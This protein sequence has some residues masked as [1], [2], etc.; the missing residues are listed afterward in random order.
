[1]P[2]SSNN[3]K[4]CSRCKSRLT[5]DDDFCPQCGKL[6]TKNANCTNHT[7]LMAE[8]VCIICGKPRCRDCGTWV[9]KRYL[10][11]AHAEYEIYEGM[12]RVFGVSDEAAAQYV[13]KCLEQEGLHPLV[14]ERKASAISVGGPDYTLFEA[15][16]EHD[17]HIIN[18]VKVMVPCREVVSA[19]RVLKKL[20]AK[21]RVRK[22][23][24]AGRSRR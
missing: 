4:V 14:Y 5:K 22:N 23:S 3:S 9:S 11:S 8:G 21:P 15:S 7:A 12:A 19:E 16:G 24:K 20:D 18:E 10:C 1:M 6:Q 17:G 2:L 13:C